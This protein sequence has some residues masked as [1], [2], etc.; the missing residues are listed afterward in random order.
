MSDEEGR[1]ESEEVVREKTDMSVEEGRTEPEEVV[2]EKTVMS[3]EEGRA[4]PEEVV[5]V[6]GKTFLCDGETMC[7]VQWTKSESS[8]ILWEELKDFPGGKAAGENF[9]QQEEIRRLRRREPV[10]LPP[11]K[12]NHNW[13]LQQ[14]P[15]GLFIR[16]PTPTEFLLRCTTLRETLQVSPEGV[17]NPEATQA[18]RTKLIS[19]MDCVEIEGLAEAAMEGLFNRVVGLVLLERLEYDLQKARAEVRKMKQN[20]DENLKTYTKRAIALWWA[21]DR[22]ELVDDGNLDFSPPPQKKEAVRIWAL[23]IRDERLDE[24][25]KA[26]FDDESLMRGKVS[27]LTTH[28]V[29]AEAWLAR[30]ELLRPR[31][32]HNPTPTKCRQQQRPLMAVMTTPSQPENNNGR[33][34]WNPTQQ[35]RPQ[36]RA[37]EMQRPGDQGAKCKHCP[38]G[39]VSTRKGCDNSLCESKVVVCFACQERSF[40]HGQGCR[41][42]GCR[43]NPET[44]QASGNGRV[45]DY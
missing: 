10:V 29:K 22:L 3:D 40:R 15:D 41:T 4:E 45:K 17:C 33:G 25:V 31:P 1:G 42:L 30:R 8:E 36:Q 39:T 26:G 43:A 11:E 37:A 38:N 16:N 14:L 6:L 7:M 13:Y 18:L 44:R 27:E 35:P 23:G 24:F 5:R 19:Q 12:M 2:R 32:R 21:I 28:R 20:A 34:Q 9:D